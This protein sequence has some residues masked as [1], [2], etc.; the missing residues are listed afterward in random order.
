M[1]QELAER[2]PAFLSEVEVYLSGDVFRANLHFQGRDNGFTLRNYRASD[3]IA[4]AVFY[5]VPIRFRRD[6]WEFMAMTEGEGP[7]RKAPQ[8]R[9]GEP[10]INSE[11]ERRSRGKAEQD[12]GSGGRSEP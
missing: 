5:D 4:L 10:N 8:R 1:V 3:S 9:V 6:V 2:L 12:K 7:R 11:E